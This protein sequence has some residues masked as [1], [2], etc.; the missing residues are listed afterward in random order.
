MHRCDMKSG[1]FLF[2]NNTKGG[3]S[4]NKFRKSQ[5]RN[6]ADFNFFKDLRTF[7]KYGNFPFCDFADRIIDIWSTYCT[8]VPYFWG[9]DEGKQCLQSQSTYRGRGEIGGV[10]LLSL[11]W[12]VHHNFA[13]DGR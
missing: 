2:Y 11:S 6:F 4:A 9:L 8:V 5:I 12:S 13:R 7:H 3:R 1:P 10:Y